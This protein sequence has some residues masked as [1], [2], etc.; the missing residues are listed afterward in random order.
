LSVVLISSDLPELLALAHRI[1]VMH[2]GRVVGGL[3]RSQLDPMAIVHMTPTGVAA[4][5]MRD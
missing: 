3:G 2:K 1:L 5:R 4:A